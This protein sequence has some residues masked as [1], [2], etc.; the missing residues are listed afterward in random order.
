MVLFQA[1]FEDVDDA[2]EGGAVVGVKAGEDRAVDV[3]D[4][5]DCV[6]LVNRDYDF[7]VAGA[8]AGDVSRKFVDISD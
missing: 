1:R 4:A 6:A 5:P 2:F 8:V 3:E 7:G